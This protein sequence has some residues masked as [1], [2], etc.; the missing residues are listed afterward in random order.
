[1][2]LKKFAVKASS[3]STVEP[4]IKRQMT[5]TNLVVSRRLIQVINRQ[6]TRILRLLSCNGHYVST[7][8]MLKE[9]RSKQGPKGCQIYQNLTANWA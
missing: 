7:L 8:L 2:L 1:M 3:D 9:M 4:T 5:G 6:L